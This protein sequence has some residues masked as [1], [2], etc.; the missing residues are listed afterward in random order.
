MQC[1]FVSVIY[2]IRFNISIFVCK[3][4]NEMYV[5]M[6][7]QLI[8]CATVRFCTRWLYRPR[9]PFNT[10]LLSF[11]IVRYS[12]F[13]LFGHKRVFGDSNLVCFIYFLFLKAKRTYTSTQLV[14]FPEIL[15]HKV[16]KYEN[17]VIKT[18]SY[19]LTHTKTTISKVS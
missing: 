10:Q 5:Y 3:H 15:L 1:K 8:M 11:L 19:D 14:L 2:I 7:G 18:S 13:F 9:H 6:I 12:Y 16:H 17:Y 4:K